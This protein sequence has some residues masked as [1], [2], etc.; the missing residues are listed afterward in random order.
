VGA[1]PA[2]LDAALR[3]FGRRSY[4]ANTDLSPE[5]TRKGPGERTLAS[6]HVDAP[7]SS[8][9][10]RN[11]ADPALAGPPPGVPRTLSR[12]AAA[13]SRSYFIRAR[14]AKPETQHLRR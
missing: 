1:V 6:N 7:L 10:S 8:V 14:L 5:S 4:F 13:A 3:R 12:A 9:L 11:G 2:S